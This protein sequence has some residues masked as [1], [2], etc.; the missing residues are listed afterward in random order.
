MKNGITVRFRQEV[1]GE[2]APETRGLH[3]AVMLFYFFI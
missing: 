2:A 1:P 3:P